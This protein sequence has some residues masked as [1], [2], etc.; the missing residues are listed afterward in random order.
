MMVSG[1]EDRRRGIEG[2]C[3]L[4]HRGTS[5]NIAALMAF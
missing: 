4:L 1:V 5:L 3:I 2:V